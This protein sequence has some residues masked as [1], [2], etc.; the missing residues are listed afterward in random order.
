MLASLTRRL[1]G[2]MGL[3]RGQQL[4]LEELLDKLPPDPPVAGMHHLSAFA[5]GVG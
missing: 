5:A 2:L 3:E 1:E 4:P